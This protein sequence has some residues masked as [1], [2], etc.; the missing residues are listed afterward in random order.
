[1]SHAMHTWSGI[2]T[3]LFNKYLTYNYISSI[4]FSY[5]DTENKRLKNEIKKLNNELDNQKEITNF[6][7]SMFE[8]TAIKH[9]KELINED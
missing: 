9:K 3:E 8:K 1:M 7:K 5:D 4:V 6:W 2:F